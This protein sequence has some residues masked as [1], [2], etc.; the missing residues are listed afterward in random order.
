MLNNYLQ[1]GIHQIDQN[2]LQNITY[3]E[4]DHI[5][6]PLAPTARTTNF[7]RFLSPNSGNA[8]AKVNFKLSHSVNF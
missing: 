5:I 3:V 1:V 6:I 2:L 4:K 7:V 8:T